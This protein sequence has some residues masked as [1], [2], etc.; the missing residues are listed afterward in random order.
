[1]ETDVKKADC[2][3]WQSYVEYLCVAGCFVMLGV[4]TVVDVGQT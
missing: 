3:E 1:M 4:E 2:G